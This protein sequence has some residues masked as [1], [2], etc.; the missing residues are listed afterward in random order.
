MQVANA[1]NDCNSIIRT[2]PGS[3]HCLSPSLHLRSPGWSSGTNFETTDLLKH[4]RIHANLLLHVG[5]VFL[6]ALAY[7]DDICAA[8]PCSCSMRAMLAVCDNY[9]AD[10]LHI[11]F[12]AKKSKCMYRGSR[13]KLQHGLPEFHIGGT[14]IEFVKKWPHLGYIISISL[15]LYLIV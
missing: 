12:N 7:A 3:T 6:W 5:R 15:C 14:A 2:L 4:F 13:L 9:Y 11:V 8:R 1:F 10:D